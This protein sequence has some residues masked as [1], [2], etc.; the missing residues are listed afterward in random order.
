MCPSA[1]IWAKTASRAGVLTLLAALQLAA[2]ETG[3][4]RLDWRQFGTVSLT[5][6][7][8]VGVASGAVSRVWYAPAGDR[9]ALLTAAGERW[10]TEDFESWKPSQAVPPE[11]REAEA[12]AVPEPSAL[13]RG[14]GGRLY[15]AGRFAWA[16][17]DEGRTW[18]NLTG[19][20]RFSI[21]GGAIADLAVSPTNPDDIAVANEHGVWRSLDGGLS[22]DS[23]NALL[24]NL[25]ARR[26]LRAPQPRQGLVLGLADGE[27]AVWAPGERT[28]WRLA[29]ASITSAERALAA[30]IAAR[31]GAV[32][33][34]ALRAGAYLYAGSEDGRLLASSDEGATWREFRMAAEGRVESLFLDPREPQIALAALAPALA[35]GARIVR[36]T[37]GGLFWDDVSANLPP[38]AAHGVTAD[39]ATGTLYAATEAGVFLTMTNLRNAA[40]ATRW[41]RIDAGLPRAAAQDVMLDGEGNQIYIALKGY[42]VYR[43]LAP[44]RLLDP[45][46][47]NAA[48]FS[49][50]AAAPGSLLSVLGRRVASARMGDSEVPV[51][52]ASES[53]SQIQVPFEAAGA[54]LS[55]S[56]AD[57]TPG[58]RSFALPLRPLSP[59]IFI[60]RDGSPMVLDAE[61]GLLLD[62][63]TQ[64]AAGGRIQILCTGLGRVTPD[65]PTGLAAPVEN[66][67]KV[68]AEVKVYLDRMP[69]TVTRATLAAGYIGFYLVEAE[70]PAVVD[71]GPAELYLEAGGSESNRVSLYLQP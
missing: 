59:A 54:T 66:L 61:R 36:T 1:T 56:L 55:L 14:A 18:R 30:S 32:V 64:A 46:V 16:S 71:A 8:T 45:R 15:A 49:T 51:L 60:G 69:L 37:N 48:D 12:S 26:L 43:T 53:E 38:G 39:L 6:P 17:D 21:L 62:A 9:L 23:L 19:H 42:G 63:Q 50:R 33:T 13:V 28:G 29:D 52:A 40:P 24:P 35:G 31:T 4:T 41:E 27:E 20:A 3:G 47:V 70:L 67:P 11:R 2:Q 7:A 25:P 58:G 57:G 44:H 68:A 34:R 65:W 10:E 5:G 22:W